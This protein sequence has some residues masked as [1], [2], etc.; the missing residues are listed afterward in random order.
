MSLSTTVPGYQTTAEVGERLGI[1]AA[2]VRQ[3]LMD[4]RAETGR[5]VGYLAGT[6]RLFSP[7]DVA[8]IQA[9]HGALRSYTKK[10]GE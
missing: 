10:L 9:A 5:D 4:I 1:S 8:V 2:R 3:L 7:A 6:V